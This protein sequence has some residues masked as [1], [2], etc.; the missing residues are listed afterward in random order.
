MESIEPPNRFVT[1]RGVLSIAEELAQLE[2]KSRLS[3][4]HIGNSC[5]I[6]TYVSTVILVTDLLIGVHYCII[7]HYHIMLYI[8]KNKIFIVFSPFFMVHH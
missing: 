6:S 1:V 8:K 3:T 5:A 7:F 4:K 2:E